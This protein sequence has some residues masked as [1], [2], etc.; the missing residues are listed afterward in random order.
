MAKKT[1]GKKNKKFFMEKTGEKFKK[2]LKKIQNT[3]K[4]KQNGMIWK[5]LI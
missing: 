2:Q 3:L 5:I 1:A 4:I